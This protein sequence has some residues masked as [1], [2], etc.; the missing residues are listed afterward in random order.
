MKITKKPMPKP[1]QILGL[2]LKNSLNIAMMDIKRILFRYGLQKSKPTFVKK[3][4]QNK[5]GSALRGPIL[6]F[7]SLFC[8]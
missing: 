2:G 1:L 4:T 6:T 7:S 8:L 5:N 3:C